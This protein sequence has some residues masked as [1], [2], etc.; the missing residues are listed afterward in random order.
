MFTP[1]VFQLDIESFYAGPQD[2]VP[3]LSRQILGLRENANR[4]ARRRLNVERPLADTDFPDLDRF[5][6]RGLPR[7]VAIRFDWATGEWSSDRNSW[8][9]SE[10]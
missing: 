2:L 3:Q 10:P 5:P 7:L 8:T 4:L 6:V 1:A 9:G